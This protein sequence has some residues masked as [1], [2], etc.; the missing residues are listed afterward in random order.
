MEKKNLRMVDLEYTLEVMGGW[1]VEP[2]LYAH[3]VFS[4]VR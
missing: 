4:Y 3:A 2:F 1:D